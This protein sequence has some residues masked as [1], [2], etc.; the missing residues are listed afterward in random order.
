VTIKSSGSPLNLTEVQTEFGGVVPI[1]I[2]EYYGLATGLPTT[3]QPI[4]MSSFYG[5]TF[6]VV[7]KITSSGTW[8]NRNRNATYVHIYVVGAGGSGGVAYPENRTVF[9]IGNQEGVGVA[10]GGGAGGV[11]YSRVAGNAITSANIVIG[12]GGAGVSTSAEGAEI[13][14]NAGSSSSFIGSSLNMVGGGGSGG[15]ANT[16]IDAQS[17]TASVPSTPGGTASGGNL[18]NFT[19]GSGGS[20]LVTTSNLG[21]GA[22][23][24]GAPA[25]EADDTTKNSPSISVNASTGVSDGAKVST[26]ST[27]PFVLGNYPASRS[28]A[29]V[30]GSL[31]TDF[32]GSSGLLQT[33]TS[34]GSPLF[35]AG[36]GG[37]SQ[38]GTPRS[39]RGGNGVVIIVYEI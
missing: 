8:V 6:L 19:G 17:T 20:V 31:I 12:T 25:F 2:S 24:G 14:G 28:Q 1:S 35:G 39:G 30:V 11:S 3:G 18:G 22:S 34:T 15:S 13:P 32:D 21:Y 4:S 27:Q 23:G 7:D 10:A 26:Y 9:L 38:R 37:S 29:R 36:S 16:V 5:K 33:N